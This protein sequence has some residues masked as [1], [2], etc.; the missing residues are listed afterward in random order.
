MDYS[1]L[2]F[3]TLQ[4]HAG[5]DPAD[6]QMGAMAVPIY[7]TTA[8][9]FESVDYAADLFALKADGNIYTRISNPTQDILEKRIAV[10]EGGIGALALASGHSAAVLTV[11]TIAQQG[12]NLIAATTIY[13]GLLNMFSKT[14]PKMG[15]DFKFNDPDDIEG[16]E[17]L[18]DDKTK[19]IFVE[20][21]G[22]PN[23]NMIDIEA[24]AKIAHKYNIPL[25]VDNT[26]GTPYF[27]KP[28]EWGADIIIHSATKYIGGHGTSM[29][30]IIVDS[31]RFDWA[32]GRFDGFTTPDPSYHGIIYAKD[33]GE[34][35]FITKARVQMLRDLGPCISPFNAFMLLQGLE[36]LSIRMERISSTALYIARQLEKNPNVSFVNHPG[37]ESSKYY[38]LTQKYMPK[39]QSGVFTFGLKGGRETGKKFMDSL[40]IFKNVAN[41]GDARSLVSHPAS[42]TH[43][44]LDDEG[45]AKAGISQETVRLSIGLEGKEDLMADLLN[46]IEKATK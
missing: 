31:G 9:N 15:I 37:L 5:Y 7:Q 8:Y 10:L 38:Q 11:L 27:V 1:K 19:G 30:G 4:L 46:A 6:Q 20:T 42:T 32:S 43:S 29:G 35:A 16:F 12:D 44:Q 23:S 14:F 26:F 21:L 45:L 3:D 33:V 34:A 36:T 24:I 17:R 18:I 39:G 25:I 22:N 2:S 41:L 28:I 13:G 40:E